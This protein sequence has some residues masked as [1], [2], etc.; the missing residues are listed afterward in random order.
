MTNALLPLVIALPILLVSIPWKMLAI[1]RI[2]YYSPRVIWGPCLFRLPLEELA[3]F[4]IA[5]LLVATLALRLGERF[6]ASS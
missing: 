6:R 5:G 4:I 3:F 1:D 2:W